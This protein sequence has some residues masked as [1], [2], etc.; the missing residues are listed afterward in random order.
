MPILTGN[1]GVERLMALAAGRPAP[2]PGFHHAFLERARALGAQGVEEYVAWGAVECAED[3]FDFSFQRANLEHCRSLGLQ[4]HVYLWV[5]VVPLWARDRMNIEGFRCL[6]HD[7]ECGWPSTFAAS[8]LELYERML[9]R[10][11]AEFGAEIDGLIVGAPADYGEFGYP[12][13]FGHWVAPLPPALAH[14]HEGFWSGDGHAHAAFR[15]FAL[16]R[17]SS[18]AAVNSAFATGFRTE[19]E[20]S[21]PH[22]DSVPEFRSTYADFYLH[23]MTSFLDAVL[24]NAR[25]AFPNTRLSFKLGHGGENLCYGIDP[26]AWAAV[27]ARH[28]AS[29]R[30]TQSTL[31]ELHHQRISAPCVFHGVSLETESPADVGREAVL[32]R[33]FRDAANGTECYFDFAEHLVAGQDLLTRHRGVLD[34]DRPWRDVAVLFP[35]MDH[36]LH[37]EWGMPPVLHRLASSLRDRFDHA[38]VD[39]QLVQGGGLHGMR[40]L[41]VPQCQALAESTRSRILE[42]VHAGAWC[43]LGPEAA[44]LD[45]LGDGRE[46]P[47]ADQA[48]T[49]QG[50]APACCEWN[51]GASGDLLRTTGH[52]YESE[53]A[54][55]FRATPPDGDPCRWAGPRA[56]LLCPVTPGV[57]HLLEV[58]A[59]VH[60]Q[61]VE[62]MHS[63]HVDGELLDHVHQ[64]GL[65]RFA[66]WIDGARLTRSVMEVEFVSEPFRPVDLGIG[67]DSRK[68]GIAVLWVRWTRRDARAWVGAPAGELEGTIDLAEL[69]DRSTHH[70]SGRIVVSRQRPLLGFVALCDAVVQQRSEANAPWARGARAP[71]V[72]FAR[73]RGSLLLHHQGES[74]ATVELELDRGR[75]RRVL[76]PGDLVVVP[77]R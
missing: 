30:T 60:P 22:P 11:A 21:A 3:R 77:T 5:H 9:A 49:F 52:W 4:W 32:T 38:L 27:A 75:E 19:R 74:T 7:R 23:A 14:V 34:G 25:R 72:Q 50:S 8:T 29:I 33:V 20:I 18:L 1:L 69:E 46:L 61:T 28:R 43:V 39:E 37:P 67:T 73:R 65:Q 51:V 54:A 41:I 70:G 63:V 45:L 24:G 42:A 44:G 36:R 31:P 76:E 71:G 40:V 47:G 57:D 56:G 53:P 6:E 17:Y 59:W 62:S 48:V 12:T 55:Q 35:T 68:L 2:A 15:E 13:G 26:T 66:A 10:L 58:E 64:P 16:D